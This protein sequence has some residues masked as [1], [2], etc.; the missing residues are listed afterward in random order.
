MYKVFNAERGFSIKDKVTCP[1][2]CQIGAKK[3]LHDLVNFNDYNKTFQVL[4]ASVS[5]PLLKK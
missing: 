5:S 4:R 1:N 2:S 3:N